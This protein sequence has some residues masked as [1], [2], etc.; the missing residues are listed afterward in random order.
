MFVL[1]YCNSDVLGPDVSNN[2]HLKTFMSLFYLL[3]IFGMLEIDRILHR[4]EK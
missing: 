2:L 1:F 4:T 3:I